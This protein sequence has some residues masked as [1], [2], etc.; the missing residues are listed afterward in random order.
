[1]QSVLDR[2]LDCVAGAL[3]LEKTAAPTGVV[4]HRSP[5]FG[6][7]QLAYQGFEFS[8]TVPSG[9]RFEMLTDATVVEIDTRLIA[10]PPPG[11]TSPG[12]VFDLVVDGELR[13][14][15]VTD[16]RT[17]VLPDLATGAFEADPGRHTTLRFPVGP[18]AGER[19]VEIWLPVAAALTLLDVRVPDGASLRPAPPA[20]PLWVH[21]GSSISQCA[22]AGRPTG[23][24]PALVSR[25]AGRSL[26]N[27]GLAGQCNLDPFMARAIRDLPAAAISLELGINVVNAD[28][29]RERTF[30]PAFHGFLD[31]IRDGHPDTPVL[32]VT[33]IVCPA[34]EERPGPMLVDPTGRAC[35]VNRPP[36]LGAGALSVRRIRELL[37]QHV[38][39][40]RKH[41]DDRLHLVHGTELFGY[42]DVGDLPDGLHPNAAGYARIADRFLPL[43]FD[44]GGALTAGP[45]A[46]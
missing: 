34:A 9:V 32:I 10:I 44:E 26:V 31:T 22:E 21:H 29:M 1:M 4:L 12:T 38:E 17:P 41:G 37:A 8:S 39:L 2:A 18:D 19:R 28:S 6:R 40:R 3:A 43:A 15:V 16:A 13:D 5:A 25:A 23:T 45:A 11:A 20:G 35:A 33:P 24:W 42:G 14:P 46:L 30:V 36:E 27:L 7:L